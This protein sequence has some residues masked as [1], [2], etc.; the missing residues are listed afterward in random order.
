MANEGAI[1]LLVNMMSSAGASPGTKEAAAG[2]IS[3]LACIKANQVSG[4]VV[5][6]GL[7]LGL[8]FCSASTVAAAAAA[9]ALVCTGQL[10]D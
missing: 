10:V 3:N 9:A 7:G 2:A 6:L 4:Q 8:F 5:R 1:P